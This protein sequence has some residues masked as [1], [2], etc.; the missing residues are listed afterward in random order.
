MSRQTAAPTPIDVTIAYAADAS[1]AGLAYAL[2]RGAQRERV[3]RIPFEAR[4]IPGHGGRE[5]GYA[6][7]LAVATDLRNRGVQ[8]V[9]LRIGD[10]ELV[11]DIRE[12]RELPTVLSIPY[13]A[14]RCALN[15]FAHAEV[16]FCDDERW[17]D[18]D[19]R[20]RADVSLHLAA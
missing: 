1:G 10:A 6:A 16:A 11:R 8:D 3:L 14:V 18:I 2:V 9:A 17:R 12:R 19:A 20:A 7:L 4:V 5:N 13:V 15:R